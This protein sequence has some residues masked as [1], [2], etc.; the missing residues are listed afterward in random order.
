[1]PEAALDSKR[2]AA[3]TLG[4]DIRPRE[5]KKSG[6]QNNME[7]SPPKPVS[8]VQAN[9]QGRTVSKTCTPTK[10]MYLQTKHGRSGVL[11]LHQAVDILQSFACSCYPP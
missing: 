1:M 11:Q 2:R 10:V 3:A 5:I 4:L 7:T 8:D 9:E 6:D